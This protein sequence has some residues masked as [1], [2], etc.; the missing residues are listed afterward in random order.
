LAG[1]PGREEEDVIGVLVVD[2]NESFREVLREVVAATAGMTCVGVA[3]SGEA[4]LDAVA[5][6]APRLVIIDKRM[7]GIGGVAAAARMRE[8]HPGVVVVLVSIETP[9]PEVL[10]QSCAAAFLDKRRVSPRALAELWRLH[11]R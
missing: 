9:R 1:V 2:D 3:S 6:L 5:E 10:E 7:P 4:A 11:G 8:R